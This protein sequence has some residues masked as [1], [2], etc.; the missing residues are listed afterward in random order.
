M[1]IQTLVLIPELVCDSQVWRHQTEYL[2]DIAQIL[3]PSVDQSSTM[4]GPCAVE[5]SGD[6]KASDNPFR[7]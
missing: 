6:I 1:T 7:L 5:W 4:V 3:V 2:S